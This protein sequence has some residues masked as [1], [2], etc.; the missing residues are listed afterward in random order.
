MQKGRFSW[1][2]IVGG[3]HGKENARQE[4]HAFGVQIG[5]VD[6]ETGGQ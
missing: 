1:F 5:A 4:F 2:F 3:I 6:S